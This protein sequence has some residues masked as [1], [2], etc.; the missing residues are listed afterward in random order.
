MA[1]ELR[2]Q[3]F[4]GTKPTEAELAERKAKREAAV[5]SRLMAITHFELE[6][7]AL[8]EKQTVLSFFFRLG[9]LS[10]A[11]NLILVSPLPL[12]PSLPSFELPLLLSHSPAHPVPIANRGS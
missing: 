10:I 11:N 6:L 3:S 9:T 5:A 12:T 4:F 8:A 1:R 7:E 2:A